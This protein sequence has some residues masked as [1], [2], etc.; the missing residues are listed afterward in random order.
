MQV[1]SSRHHSLTLLG[2]VVVAQVLLLAVQIKREQQVRL[3]RLWAVEAVTPLGRG[4]A[5][6]SDGIGGGW[7]NYV[8]LRHMRSENQQLHDELDQMKLRD[9]ELQGRAAEADRLAGLLGFRDAHTEVPMLAARVIGASPDAGSHIIFLSRGSRDGVRRD[10]GVITPEGVVGKVI[11]VFPDTS[12]V[13]LLDDKESGVGALLATTRTQSPVRGTGDPALSMEYISNDVKVQSGEAVLTSGQ[14]RIFPKDLPVGTVEQAVPDK[15]SPFQAV[16]IKPA[17]HLDQL[18]EV[19][20]LL[21]RQEFTPPKDT[22]SSSTGASG[23]DASGA[24]PAVA[25]PAASANRA[26]TLA[27]AGASPA[28][29]S[30]ASSNAAANKHP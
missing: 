29:H 5:W 18:E 26:S 10:M 15:H 6:I 11:A 14:D 4:A 25:A 13:L 12:Q 7:S 24:T 2:I 1:T 30:D 19:L 17:A 23:S 8:A 3:I 20:V 22:D 16:T 21:S 28:V 9:A 27:P